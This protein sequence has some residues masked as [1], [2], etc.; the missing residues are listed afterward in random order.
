MKLS[1]QKLMWNN[2]GIIREEKKM[3]ETLQILDKYG[4]YIKQILNKGTNK[5]ILELNNLCTVAKLIT[6]SALD[7]KESVGTHFVV[8]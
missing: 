4:S 3:K 1:I 2:V 6:E 5:E 7:R 8:T